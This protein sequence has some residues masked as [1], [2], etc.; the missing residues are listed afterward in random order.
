MST[1]FL[2]LILL[3]GT[4]FAQHLQASKFYKLDFVVKEVEGTKVL[5]ARAYSMFV[6]TEPSAAPGSIRAGSRV[7]VPQSPG[8]SQYT[9]VELGVNID[10]RSVVELESDLS[11]SITADISGALQ[12]T[13]T[14][15]PA[16]VIRNNRWT[17]TVIIPVRKPTVVFSSDDA[18]TK[19]Q[20]QLEVTATPLK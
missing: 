5:N 3:A 18:T 7:P 10:C 11:M 8:S 15:N 9:Y 12:D 1:R 17:S 13:A 6:S 4:C 19:R 16:P 14:S 2:P 20:L